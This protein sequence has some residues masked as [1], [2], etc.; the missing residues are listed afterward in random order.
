MKTLSSKKPATDARSADV[1]GFS[2]GP[3]F[4]KN[5]PDSTFQN[6]MPGASKGIIITI[7]VVGIALFISCKKKTGV[8][9]SPD[10]SGKST[11]ESA[12]SLSS[13]TLDQK[14]DFLDNQL[15]DIAKYVVAEAE[16]KPTSRAAIYTELEKN[17][18][19]EDNALIELF[20]QSIPALGSNNN[21]KSSLIQFDNLEGN[22]YFPQVFISNYQ[23]LKANN[24]I[25]SSSKITAVFYTGDETIKVAQAYTLNRLGQWE[26]AGN[27]S[28]EDANGNEVWIFSLNET[29]INQ[30][31]LSILPDYEIN[32]PVNQ[33]PSVGLDHIGQKTKTYYW[34]YFE[35]MRVKSH[36]ES[37]IAG[38]LEVNCKTYSFWNNPGNINPV[39][40]IAKE[41][42]WVHN[43]N[44]DKRI[45]E[46]KRSFV[47]NTDKTVNFGYMGSWEP[48]SDFLHGWPGDAFIYVIYENDI[49]PTGNKNTSVQY[50]TLQTGNITYRSADTYYD[51]GVILYWGPPGTHM[52][53]YVRENNETRFNSRM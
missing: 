9:G 22:K 2:H 16:S 33:G 46:F 32:P 18:D 47:P 44:A 21:F 42:M 14:R 15:K 28:E 8:D 34:P 4:Q 1:G 51:Q 17:I 10:L 50:G 5:K 7:T 19:R 48:G 20:A 39:T 45:A 3:D 13:L 40:H 6:R 36:K 29:F 35:Q 49:W 43:A 23:D 41:I 37:W 52:G 30:I 25:G 38:Q 11:P 24:K 12:I 53:D 27:V 26:E 31:D